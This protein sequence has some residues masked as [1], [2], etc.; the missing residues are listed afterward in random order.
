MPR[1]NG[2]PTRSH[3]HIAPAPNEERRYF[4]QIPQIVWA[5]IRDPYDLAIWATVKMI[6]GEAG[7]CWLSLRRLARLAACSHAKA[8][9]SIRWL[10]RVELLDGEKLQPDKEKRPGQRETG[11]V[12]AIP[13]LWE[14]NTNYRQQIVSDSLYE[15]IEQID[16][17]R[18]N[19]ASVFLAYTPELVECKSH[20]HSQPQCISGIH[21]PDECIS[22]IHSHGASMVKNQGVEPKKEE[23]ACWKVVQSHLRLQLPRTTFD[24][25]IR[26]AGCHQGRSEEQIIIT[27]ENA[28]AR[29][30]LR[31]R[32]APLIRRTM[33]AVLGH[34]VD[35][36]FVVERDEE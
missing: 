13:D 31:L 30:W 22:G 3:I 2:N 27:V 11:W 15:R 18:A 24:T 36:E 8:E 12:L 26:D 28:Y 16:E 17:L 20:R 14:L 9:D 35:L 19:L 5:R 29:D 21:S 25:W 23:L 10:I 1:K 34:A 33:A 4:V 7:N 6:A 32:L